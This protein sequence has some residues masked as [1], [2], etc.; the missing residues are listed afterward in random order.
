MA[1]K[2]LFENST[3]ESLNLDNLTGVTRHTSNGFIAL[4]CPLVVMMNLSACLN[5]SILTFEKSIL[6]NVISLPYGTIKG[7][8]ESNL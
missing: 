6:L 4:Y 7:V 2:Y 1:L 8:C 3:I 5:I